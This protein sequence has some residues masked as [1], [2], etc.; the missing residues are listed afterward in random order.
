MSTFT[1]GQE[2]PHFID[3]QEMELRER[4]D[5]LIEF[6]LPVCFRQSFDQIRGIRI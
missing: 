5:P 3:N 4:L 6:V 1:V 2:I